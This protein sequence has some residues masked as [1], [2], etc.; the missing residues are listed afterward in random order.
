MWNTQY[1]CWMTEWKVDKPVV[2]QTLSM[3][4]TCCVLAPFLTIKKVRHSDFI[5]I[6]VLKIITV[7][8]NFFTQ[9]LYPLPPAP[10]KSPGAW[11]TWLLSH[12]AEQLPKQAGEKPRT[13][14]PKASFGEDINEKILSQWSWLRGEKN[15]ISKSKAMNK[16]AK[17]SRN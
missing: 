9:K 12:P 5:V 16:C 7:D 2:T 10:S 4:S 1:Q 15:F 8:I 11:E 14:F 17:D 6:K 13:N 3:L